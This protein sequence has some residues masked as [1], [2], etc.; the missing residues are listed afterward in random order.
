MFKLKIKCKTWMICDRERKS[1]ECTKQNRR[2]DDN[3]HIKCFFFI[4][5]KLNDEN[6]D[7]WIFKI[8]NEDHNHASNIVDVYSMLRRMTMTREMKIE[9][10]RQLTIQMKKMNVYIECWMSKKQRLIINN[11]IQI[12]S[13]KIISI[14]R[15]FIIINLFII[16]TFDSITFESMSFDFDFV[17]INLLIKIRN[18]YNIK[19]QMRRDEL[20]SM[21]SM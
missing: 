8:K 17:F 13:F 5:I 1:H 9:I 16:F 2:H 11:I 14:V 19:T 12:A 7:F 3:K 6:V 10:K 15:F 4:V 20:E 18:V 21:I